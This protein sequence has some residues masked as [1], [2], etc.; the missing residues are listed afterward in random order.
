M[1]SILIFNAPG[2]FGLV[3]GRDL[4]NSNDW[5]NWSVDSEFRGARDQSASER[6]GD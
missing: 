5:P 6:K 4:A 1:D 2:S 3:L